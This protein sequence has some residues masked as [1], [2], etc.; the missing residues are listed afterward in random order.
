MNEIVRRRLIEAERQL[1]SINQWYERAINSDRNWR[2]S[3]REEERLRGRRDIGP[4][5]SRQNQEI[6]WQILPQPQVWARRQEVPQQW[7]Q[8]GPTPMEGVK[9]TNAVMVCS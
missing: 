6:Q 9:R 1:R 2:E 3:R 7:A 4:Q 8:V 5:T